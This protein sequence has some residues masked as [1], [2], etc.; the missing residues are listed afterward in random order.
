[1]DKSAAHATPARIGA[2]SPR[3]TTQPDSEGREEATWLGRL[4]ADGVHAAVVK[5]LEGTEG[6][7]RA[8]VLD[9]YLGMWKRIAEQICDACEAADEVG[10]VVRNAESAAEHLQRRVGH[11]GVRFA[12]ERVWNLVGEI[13]R[14]AKGI[15]R[16][17]EGGVAR[18]VDGV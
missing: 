2:P 15:S 16:D 11:P 8:G 7:E 10:C 13:E 18:A 9:E 4:R 6:A 17:V 3:R 12:V 5:R 14:G 1:M